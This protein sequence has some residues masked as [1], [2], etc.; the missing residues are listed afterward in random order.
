[1]DEA[2]RATQAAA[3]ADT[4]QNHDAQYLVAIQSRKKSLADLTPVT[5]AMLRE[6]SP[7]D[8]LHWRRTYDGLGFG[9]IDQIN[10]S[11]ARNLT[12]AWSLALPSSATDS[13]TPLVHDGVM[14]VNSNGTVLAINVV[15]SD[16]LWQ[17]DSSTSNLPSMLASQPRS[18]A[19]YGEKLYVPTNDNRMV[20]LDIRSGRLVWEHRIATSGGTVQITAGP[21]VAHGNVFQGMTGC[22]GLD[23]PGGCFLVALD[24]E[25]GEERWR[26]YTIQKPSGQGVDTWN[27][28]P[29]DQRSGASIWSTATYDPQAGLIFFGTGQTY[30]IAPL[31][32]KTPQRNLSN[33]AL[34]T[35]T[36]LA[37][38]SDTGKLAWFYQH[39]ARD[40]WD[41][42]WA[43]G[44]QIITMPGKTGPQKVVETMGKLGILDVLD[45]KTGKYLFSYDL[46]FQNLVQ[47]FDRDTGKKI[48]DP[49]LEPDETHPKHM[50][51]YAT[52]VR[53]WPATSYDPM[54]HILFVPFTNSCMKYTYNKG[55]RTDIAFELE[56]PA[57]GDGNFGGVAAINLVSRRLE[58]E[59]RYRAPTASALLATAGGLLF[60]GARDR[61]VRA[62][63]SSTGTLLWSAQL[64]QVASSTPVTFEANGV[65]YVS[66]TTGGGSYNDLMVRALTP[67]I[68]SGARGSGVRLWVF[69]LA[70]A[71]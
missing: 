27:G 71:P 43:F 62:Y 30:H 4:V 26:F 5:D 42:D 6:P 12:L 68:D 16:I 44:R 54:Q 29:G 60:A 59:T 10:R 36:T 61:V 58:W 9:P 24:A 19:I 63:D 70:A 3:L 51:P 33:A 64:D 38:E 50:C 17:F 18:M 7:G 35:D 8:W 52:G 48:T 40:V 28:V 56:R 55:H 34:Y 37:L 45:A 11:N 25:T 57:G 23:A 14:F 46:G 66:V 13:I 32:A 53:N 67:E 41:M 47:T 49:A 20:A 15:S 22:E 2:V 31:M 65:Q 21:I 39:M 1:L 69:R